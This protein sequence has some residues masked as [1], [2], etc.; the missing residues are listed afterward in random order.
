M[1]WSRL[2]LLAYHEEGRIDNSPGCGDD[3]ASAPVQGL[4]SNHCI[5]DLK[6]DISNH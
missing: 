3:L 5:Q 2:A 1:L 4:L 6:L